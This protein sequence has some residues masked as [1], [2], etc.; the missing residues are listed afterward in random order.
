MLLGSVTRAFERW[1]KASTGGCSRS[2]CGTLSGTPAVPQGLRHR[3]ARVEY[4]ATG[5]ARE[6]H[7]SLTA[8][9]EW[10]ERHRADIAAARSF[11][12]GKC[13]GPAA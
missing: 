1:S 4:T 2:R 9:T 3:A 5:M 10:A 13:D 11:Y 6:L 7:D 12:D 8:P